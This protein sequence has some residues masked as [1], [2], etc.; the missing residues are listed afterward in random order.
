MQ[1]AEPLAA[2]PSGRLGELDRVVLIVVLT[3]VLFD[4]LAYRLDGW[5]RVGGAGRDRPESRS[6]AGWPTS[7]R[8]GPP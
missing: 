8:R 2:L 5:E 3:A 4:R 1:G 6:P 7:A